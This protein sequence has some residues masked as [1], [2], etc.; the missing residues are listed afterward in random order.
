LIAAGAVVWDGWRVSFTGWKARSVLAT[1]WIA[2]ASGGTFS[3][4]PALPIAPIDSD[5]RRTAD[6]MH[7][8]YR[9]Q[10]DCGELTKT[11]RRQL[12]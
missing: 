10:I 6:Q 4:A 2:L 8:L 7:D 5:L 12:A 1:T 3:V 11:I 9:E